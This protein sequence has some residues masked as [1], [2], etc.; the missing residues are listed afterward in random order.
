MSSTDLPKRALIVYHNNCIDGFTS[1]W[2]TYRALEKQGFQELDMLA[3]SYSN[4]TDEL[5]LL[6]MNK[7]KKY[8]DIYVVDFSLRWDVIAMLTVDGHAHITILDH[9]KTAF[10]LYFPD[11]EVHSKSVASSSIG[12]VSIYLINHHCG[13]AICWQFFN[14]EK[15]MP[16]LIR[17]VEDNDLWNYEYGDRT[18]YITRL[19][20]NTEFTLENWDALTYKMQNNEGHGILLEKGKKLQEEWIKKVVE[21]CDN[22]FSIEL[23]GIQGLATECPPE[24]SSDVGNTLLLSS[25]TFGACFFK[26]EEDKIKWSVRSNKGGIDASKLAA[27]YG[28]GGHQSAAGFYTKTTTEVFTNE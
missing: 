4:A 26:V 8:K 18:K 1:A 9:H 27:I 15:D 7:A 3:M 21:Y 14:S 20:G 11:T 28:G 12:R 22:S 25:N 13:A 19:L 5:F 23:D 24:Y 17:Y 2:V 6:E 10:E 16:R